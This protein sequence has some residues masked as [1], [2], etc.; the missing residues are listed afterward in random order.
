MDAAAI[1]LAEA[2]AAA[3]QNEG[4]APMADAR[5]SSEAACSQLQLGQ[6][7]QGQQHQLSG[8]QQQVQ[9]QGQQMWHMHQQMQALYKS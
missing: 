6:A 1:G 8:Q 7:T 5:A 4:R 3:T 2:G 9:W